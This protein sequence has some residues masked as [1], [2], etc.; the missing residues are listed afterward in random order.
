MDKKSDHD[1]IMQELNQKAKEII[2][3]E[4]QLQF[5]DREN[6]RLNHQIEQHSHSKDL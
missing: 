5:K 6:E 4:T 1:L 2:E 3:Y